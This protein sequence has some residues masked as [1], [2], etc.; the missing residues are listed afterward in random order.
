MTAR[1]PRA[2]AHVPELDG[3]R[4]AAILMVMGLHFVCTLV[5]PQHSRLEFI[6]ARLTGYGAWGVDLFFVL[7]GFLITGI[8]WDSRG[9]QRYFQTFYARRTLR[10]FPLYYA[11]LF[12]L[13][14]LLP[15]SFIVAHVP[16]VLEVR[17]VQGYLWP[18][19]AN[20]YIA[21]QG[22]F[23]I[24]YV[25]HFWTLAIEE[26]FYL[27]WPFVVGLASRGAIMKTCVVLSCLSLALR[28]AAHF[29]GLNMFYGHVLTPCRLDSLCIGSWL[30]LAARGPTGL[31]GLAERAKP[32]LSFAF[33]GIVVTSIWHSRVGGEG[34]IAECV[35]DAFLALFFG[36]VIVLSSSPRGPVWLK[37]SLRLRAL[38]WLGKY[39]YGLYVFHGM[40][41]YYF[42]INHTLTAFT[43]V[44]GSQPLALFVQ[45]LVGAL[46]S[47][48]IAVLSY[49]LFEVHFLRL[50]KLFP[51]S[52]AVPVAASAAV[53]P[54]STPRAD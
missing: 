17:R 47:T 29:A 37:A 21:K 43:R 46:G 38:R 34:S 50:K 2:E 13:T 22:W 54:E 24:P 27:F 30:A 20:V 39:S 8:L 23:A 41:A 28:I 19:L 36:W 26:H 53:L 51:G 3:I 35:R 11:I 31:T 1:A 7:S 49:E 5:P 14:V 52:S 25:S 40:V 12:V 32:V 18:Y 42:G 4:G 33:V 48:L 15:T 16:G 45:A 6:A 9:K 10:I 44:L